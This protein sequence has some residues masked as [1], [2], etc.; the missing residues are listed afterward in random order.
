MR[1]KSVPNETCGLAGPHSPVTILGMF[2]RI[3]LM[4]L[5]ARLALA[6]GPLIGVLLVLAAAHPVFGRAGGGEG[7]S[8]GGS[9]GG[10][11]GG[12][13]GGA[14]M[15]LLVYLLIQQPEIGI[16]LV[17]GCGIFYYFTH[18]GVAG[19]VRNQRTQNGLQAI[20]GNAEMAALSALKLRDPAF[21]PDAF[22]QRISAAF[23]KIQDAWSAQ[24]VATIRAFISDGVHERFKIQFLQQ[25]AEG[26]R[27]RMQ[28][29]NIEHIALMHLTSDNVFDSAT[30]RIDASALDQHI[31]LTD[32][33][34]I[35]GG[36]SN[37][38]F[39]EYWTF[40]RRRGAKT[41]NKNGLIEGC[42]PNCGAPI[43]INAEARCRNCQAILRSGQYDWVLVNIT[44]ESQW[45]PEYP[46]NLPGV[47]D[48]EQTDPDFNVPDI[49]DRVSVMFWRKALADRL[50][51]VEPLQ[52]NASPEFCAAYAQ[53][54]HA[55]LGPNRK[56]TFWGDCAVGAVDTLGVIPAQPFDRVLVEV[57]ASARLYEDGGEGKIVR[58]MQSNVALYLFV[59]KRASGAK[60]SIAAS[61]AAAHC[62]SCGAPETDDA[63]STCSF[64]GT[65]L[66]DGSN[67][68]VL[69]DILP[70][71]G[72]AAQVLIHQLQS[73]AS[74]ADETDPFVQDQ[75]V[76]KAN[77]PQ[78]PPPQIAGLVAWAVK[79]TAAGNPLDAPTREM[80]SQVARRQNVSEEQLHRLLEAAQNGQLQ[81]REPASGAEVRLWLGSLIRATLS[82]GP[83]TPSERSL[84]N[85]VGAKYSLDPY[86]V[87]TI[88]KEQQGALYS[89]AVAALR[90]QKANRATGADPLAAA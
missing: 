11:G 28:R 43:A 57:H 49:E 36:F 53:L 41:T 62:P 17:I 10:G 88:I 51:K 46:R 60:T 3:A 90:R 70:M 29:V 55:P 68:W 15:Y 75:A 2:K 72:D 80:L 83:L 76:V 23:L 73:V 47:G 50:G 66:N 25:Q 78:R 79:T 45:Q 67:G 20:D 44:Q 22:Y 35:S 64:C 13:G 84:F 39:A 56:R 5:L 42:C 16:P 69:S 81:T 18:R 27:D 71:S 7:F 24:N 63:S 9:G 85:A 26:Y 32:G 19:Y 65:P 37:A 4:R 54:L 14:L 48:L 61:I 77:L 52:K 38:A 1:L 30:V 34:V 58:M 12:G 89:D 82:N 40:L 59:L 6:G 31:S 87:R 21:S 8:G 33:S 74:T 86:D